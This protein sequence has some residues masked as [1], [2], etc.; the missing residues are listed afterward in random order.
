MGLEECE[1]IITTG[2]RESNWSKLTDDLAY[3][4]VRIFRYFV[5]R[6]GLHKQ[7]QV[8]TSTNCLRIEV[9]VQP[10]TTIRK[11]SGVPTV[12]VPGGLTSG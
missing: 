6:S 9:G 5:S 2:S 8:L 1:I 3:C 10:T 4:P 12:T 11:T 7:E